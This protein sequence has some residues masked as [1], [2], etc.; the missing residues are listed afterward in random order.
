M[1][2]LA[3]TFAGGVD[4]EP[5]ITSTT[6]HRQQRQKQQHQQHLGDPISSRSAVMQPKTTQASRQQVQRLASSA[7]RPAQRQQHQQ[8][9]VRF[10]HQQQRP[11][12]AGPLTHASSATRQGWGTA[13]ASRSVGGGG[14]WVSPSRFRGSIVSAAFAA[15]PHLG[16][17]IHGGD[18]YTFQPRVNPSSR[19]MVQ[20]TYPNTF[21]QRIGQLSVP[22]ALQLQRYEEVSSIKAD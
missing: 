3:A 9:K 22:K 1:L 21:E 12:S 16:G 4:T 6:Q 5:D 17:T 7:N 10:Q 2:S 14:G 13:G 11:S 15:S 19:R 20:G 18:D 8:H